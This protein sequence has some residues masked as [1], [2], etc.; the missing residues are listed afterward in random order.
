MWS[1][2]K[3]GGLEIMKGILLILLYLL[4][5]AIAIHRGHGSVGGIITLNIVTGWTVIGWFLAL[6][7]AL[8]KK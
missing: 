8:S 3:L 6:L 1:T 5:S 7:W 2:I 4:P